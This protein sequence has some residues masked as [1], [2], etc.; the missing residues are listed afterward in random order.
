M[1]IK[2]FTS[3][4]LIRI[5]ALGLFLFL[6]IGAPLAFGQSDFTPPTLLPGDDANLGG[7]GDLCIGLANAIRTGDISLRQVPCFIKYFSQTLI[8]IAGSLAVI[9][10]MVGGYRYTVGS[11]EDKD[12][13]K[14]TITYALI[15]LA[16]SLMAWILVD[17]VL[18]FVTE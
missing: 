4:R 18:Q 15:G 13:A 16:V 17:V 11:D 14:K 1:R 3:N 10:V 9:F 5:L 7:Y 2:R 8:A 6:I 12:A